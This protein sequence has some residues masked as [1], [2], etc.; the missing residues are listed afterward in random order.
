MRVRKRQT[1]E[2]GIYVHAYSTDLLSGN[3]EFS[4][5]NVSPRGSYCRKRRF[6]GWIRANGKRNNSAK[7]N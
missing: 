7:S 2:S 4:R 3:P 5:I 6:D 1:L